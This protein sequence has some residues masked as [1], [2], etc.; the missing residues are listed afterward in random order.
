MNFN[1]AISGGTLATVLHGP[2]LRAARQLDE[3]VLRNVR[4]FFRL[5]HLPMSATYPLVK[6]AEKCARYPQ[7]ASRRSF[8]ELTYPA[9]LT[10]LLEV[11]EKR[12]ELPRK[13]LPGDALSN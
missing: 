6:P 10:R 7:A 1:F 5:A 13:R 2:A 4:N 11:M 12:A 3:N 8:W 9:H